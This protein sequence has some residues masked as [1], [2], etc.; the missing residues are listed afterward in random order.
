VEKKEIQTE[1]LEQTWKK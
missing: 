1:N